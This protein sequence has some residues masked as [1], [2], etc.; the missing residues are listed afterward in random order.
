[1]HPLRLFTSTV[2]FFGSNSRLLRAESQLF[3]RGNTDFP[4]LP[5]PRFLHRLLPTFATTVERL[6]THPRGESRSRGP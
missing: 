3:I 1:V 5:S 6:R 2:C 4:V